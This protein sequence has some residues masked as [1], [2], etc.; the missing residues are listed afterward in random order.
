MTWRW[1]ALLAGWAIGGAVA[2]LA[3]F[4]G[5][6][7]ATPALLLAVVV[8]C[9]ALAAW[10]RTRLALFWSSGAL[11]LLVLLCL[12]TP[13]LRGPLN[14]LIERQPPQKADVIVILGGGVKCGSHHLGASSAARLQQGLALWRAGYA[15]AV[16]LSQQSGLLGPPDC[17]KI[18][19]LSQDNIGALYGEN[20]PKVHL[21]SQVVTTRDEAARVRQLAQQHG[22]KRILLVTSPTHSRR[23]KALFERYGL[24][25]TST[26]A[27][28]Y[29]YDLT[30]P[31]PQDR[32]FALQAVL[33]E[34]I[35]RLKMRLGGTPER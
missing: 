23:A 5:E 8:G 33:Y 17:P 20:G 25:V 11:A 26:P 18:S 9:G 15:P 2:T 32:L 19:Q 30:L 24:T 12:L 27:P 29:T 16:T 35:S 28:E 22:W 4:L 10:S 14:A 34:S 3:A 31:L 6:L 21:L 1:T 7:R 13:L